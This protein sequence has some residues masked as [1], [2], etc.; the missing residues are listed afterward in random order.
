M[1]AVL[2]AL[3]GLPALQD[4]SISASSE[5]E[6]QLKAA[7]P[8][9]RR[10]NGVDISPHAV[11]PL[12]REIEPAPAPTDDIREVSL[13]E[14]DLESVAVL[15]GGIKSLRGKLSTADD[16]RLTAQFDGHIRN[17]M[18]QL[19]DKLDELTD[20]FERQAEIVMVSACDAAFVKSLVSFPFVHCTYARV[21]AKYRLYDICY[22]ESVEFAS[23][24]SR[25]FGSVSLCRVSDGA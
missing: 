24:Q 5:D 25:E 20:P 4:L 2:P 7:L 18:G 23:L 19:K 14:G 17:A 12:P 10:L 22:Q 21:Q 16:A 6:A 15:F 11:A 8:G 13:T 1:D 3:R 9:L